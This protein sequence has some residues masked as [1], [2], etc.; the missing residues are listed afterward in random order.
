MVKVSHNHLHSATQFVGQIYIDHKTAMVLG[1]NFTRKCTD[2][3][4]RLNRV[5]LKTKIIWVLPFAEL[6]DL[7][8]L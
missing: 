5:S 8:S 6:H 4:N 1:L 3:C 7:S 2:M